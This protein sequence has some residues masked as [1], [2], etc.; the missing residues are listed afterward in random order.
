MS[1]HLTN[2]HAN[3]VNQVDEALRTPLVWAAIR[4]DTAIMSQ[5]IENGAD[6]NREDRRGCTALHFSSMLGESN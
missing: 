3:E 2:G 6:V 5:L 1:L 4:G